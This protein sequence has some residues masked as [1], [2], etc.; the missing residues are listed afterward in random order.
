[1]MKN[2]LV[3]IFYLH[4]YV[5]LQF[6]SLHLLFLTLG[7]VIFVRSFMKTAFSYTS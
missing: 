2:V 1:M 7:F 4:Y 5:N 3:L 6:F